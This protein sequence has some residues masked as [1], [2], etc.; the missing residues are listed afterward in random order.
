MTYKAVGRSII[1]QYTQNETLRIS[2]G[3]HRMSSVDHL[4]AEAS[5]LKVREHSEPLSAQ[6]L[7]RCLEPGNVNN[8]ITTR[9]TPKRRMKETVFTRHRS[10]VEPTMIAKD[11]KATLH[12]IHTKAV[13]EAVTSQGRNVV[14]EDPPPL[15]NIS[16]K[17]LTRK[18]RTTLTQLRSGHCIL[19]GSYKSRISKNASLDFC[20]KTPHDVKHLFNFQLIQRQF[21]TGAPQGGILSPTLFN[22][23]TA[24]IPP[25]RAPV[26]VMAY[27]GDITITSTHTSTSAAKKYIQPYLHKFLTGQNNLTLNTDK[28]TRTLFTPDLAEYTSNLDLKINN[29]VLPM[30]SHPKVLGLTLD[31]KLTYSTHI[32]NISVQAH[33]PLQMI[34]HSQQQEG[35]NRRRHSWLPIRQS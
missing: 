2:T 20:A 4:P 29:T 33:N 9:N 26:Q 14:L 35:V 15:I 34:K 17:E 30:A 13:N 31:P 11:R 19:H 32:H 12:A 1:N 22:I 3:C 18:E 16:E 6:Y 21:K 25:P 7:A 8:S 23:Y 28:T 27:A 5:V 24:D 10:T